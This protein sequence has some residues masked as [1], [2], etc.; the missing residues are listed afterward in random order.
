MRLVHK[1]LKAPRSLFN[2]WMISTKMT[3]CTFNILNCVNK[4]ISKCIEIY[5]KE[6]QHCSQLHIYTQEGVQT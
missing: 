4:V 6:T 1:H 5:F 2:F 3:H